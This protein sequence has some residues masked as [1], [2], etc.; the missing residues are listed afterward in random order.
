[1]RIV[2]DGTRALN[3]FIDTLVIFTLAY[4]AFQGW[5]WY[6]RYW[7]YK[8]YNFGWFF[9]GILFIYYSFFE[10]VFTRTPAKWFTYSKVVNTAGKRPNILWILVRSLVRLTIIDMFFIPFLGRPLHDYLSKTRV[11]EA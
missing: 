10:I 6:V 3:F 5:N 2:G 1:M 8:P 11:I 7:G 9:F 4:F